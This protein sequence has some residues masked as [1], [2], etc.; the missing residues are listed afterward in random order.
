VLREET[1]PEG[2]GHV[3]ILL[4]AAM[5]GGGL[6]ALCDVAAFAGHLQDSYFDTVPRFALRAGPRATIYYQPEVG[7]AACHLL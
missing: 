4:L 3:W 1:L 6:E 2:D 5:A 7:P